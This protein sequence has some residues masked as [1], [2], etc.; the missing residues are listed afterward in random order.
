MKAEEHRDNNKKGSLYSQSECSY[1][2][3]D[4]QSLFIIYHLH[5]VLDEEW[6]LNGKRE[7]EGEY[8]VEEEKHEKFTITETYTICYP[9]AV[10]VHI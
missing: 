3:A 8:Y 1:D 2:E 6:N 4:G 10:V 9:R 5:D 7:D